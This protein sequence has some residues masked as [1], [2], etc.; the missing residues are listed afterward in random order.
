MNE[1]ITVEETKRTFVDVSH[2]SAYASSQP[3]VNQCV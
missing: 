1:S 3:A 2:T